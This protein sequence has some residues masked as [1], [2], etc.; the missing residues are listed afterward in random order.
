[1]GIKKKAYEKGDIVRFSN[2][3]LGTFE[4]CPRCFWLEQR[5]GIKHPRGPFPSLP[6]GVDRVLKTYFDSHVRAGTFPPEM[7]ELEGAKPFPDREKLELWRNWRNLI[8]DIDGIAQLSGAL[9]EI[10][11][12]PDGLCSPYDYKTRG[13][14]PMEGASEEY[15][16]T[17]LDIYHLLMEKGCELPLNGR[18]FLGYYW[19]ENVTGH[20]EFKFNTAVVELESDPAR[21]VKL[22]HDAVKCLESDELPGV[23]MKLDKKE[24]SVVSCEFCAYALAYI[25]AAGVQL[26]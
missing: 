22:V 11:V 2:S 18:A 6:G 9:D 12:W 21:A 7:A 17:Q 19:P 8:I 14:A 20:G 24:N 10:I 13:A 3:T 15:Y 16:G 1:M 5:H 25:D 26:P 23:P 4:E